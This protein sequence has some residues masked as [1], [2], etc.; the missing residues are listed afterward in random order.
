MYFFSEPRRVTR[1]GP[2]PESFFFR[3]LFCISFPS[4]VGLPDRA[5]LR[6]LFI[7]SGN[8]VV[9]FFVSEPLRVARSDPRESCYFFRERFGYFF[10]SPIGWSD[11]IP[12]G[13]FLFFPGI[14]CYFFSEPRRVTRSDPSP[15]SFYF[16]RELRRH[17][18][19]PRPV[20]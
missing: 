13:T 3:E 7:F 8:Y 6:R 16:F 9:D 15:E 4:P 18:F 5:P 2:S 17:F 11:Q 1:S 12:S 20:G 10:P 19:V 14:I